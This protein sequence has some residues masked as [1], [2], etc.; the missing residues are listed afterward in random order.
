MYIR[1]DF[2]H[3]RWLICYGNDVLAN[4]VES[5]VLNVNERK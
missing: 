4:F 3:Y 1:K 2:I 5:K